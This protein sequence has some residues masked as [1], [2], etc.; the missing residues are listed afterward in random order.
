[1]NP[2]IN[3]F[4]LTIENP[5]IAKLVNLKVKVFKD[6]KVFNLSG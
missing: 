4:N 5:E 3:N 1:M 2:K 6:F